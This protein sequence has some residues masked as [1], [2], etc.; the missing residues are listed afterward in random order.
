MIAGQTSEITL[1]LQGSVTGTG[2]IYITSQ[3]TK[4]SVYLDGKYLGVYTP[5][6]LSKI[7][8]GTHTIRLTKYGY[9]ALTQGVTVTAGTTTPVSVS[10][11]P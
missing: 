2:S 3:P 11:T 9:K 7:P 10:L 1:A 5:T 6:T 4:A 8:A